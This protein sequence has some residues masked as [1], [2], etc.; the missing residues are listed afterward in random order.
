MSDEPLED[1]CSPPT[2][3]SVDLS[4][5]L[6]GTHTPE[7]PTLM[8]RT[9]GRCLLYAGRVHSFHGETE[10]FKSGVSQALA[11]QLILGGLD[12]LY[13]D[14]ESDADTV[15]GRLLEMGATPESIAAHL[16]YRNPGVKPAIDVHELMAFEE[17]LTR[18]YAL[19]VVDGVTEAL[20]I[21]GIATIDNDELTGWMRAVPRRIAA[22][23]GAAVVLV[24]HVTKNAE[25][26][27]RFAIGGQ[28]KMAALDGAA[29]VIEIVEPLGRGMRGVVSLRVAK[30]RPGSVRA[31]AGVFRKT[32]RTAEAARVVVDSR[33]PGRIDVSFGPPATTAG[34]DDDGH[35]PFRPTSLM[36]RLSDGLEHAVEPMTTNKL[37]ERVTGN[38]Q[39]MATALD[40]LVQEGHVDR[41][42]GPR[43]SKILRL[44]RPYVSSSDPLSDT[45]SGEEPVTAIPSDDVTSSWFPHLESGVG[46]SVRNQSR[47]VPWNRSGTSQE[48]VA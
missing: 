40:V 43:N 24:D 34:S 39:A 6:D 32:D 16:D 44:L 30:D 46:E 8:P 47:P 15:V 41:A 1:V 9:D 10:T 33:I 14:F 11:C 17:L 22:S 38:R 4:A 5:Y 18:R 13:L 36:Q 20:H 28:A 7:V 27:G 2:W 12:V 48:P 26:R 19:A 25:S 21:F 29:Y 3:G 42:D 37:L 31:H 35:A 45:F 23:T